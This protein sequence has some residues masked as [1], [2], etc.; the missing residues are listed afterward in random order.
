MP[1]LLSCAFSEAVQDRAAMQAAANQLDFLR[2]IRL[3][4][5]TA[6][7]PLAD[8]YPIA[9]FARSHEQPSLAKVR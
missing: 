3:F 7:R 6:S 1:T 4:L 8:S 9:E 2:V 5:Q